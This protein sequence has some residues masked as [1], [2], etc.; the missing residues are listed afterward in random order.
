MDTQPGR[1][2]IRQAGSQPGSPSPFSSSPHLPISSSSLQALDGEA[3]GAEVVAQ[4]VED[5]AGAHRAAGL[6]VEEQEVLLDP[7]VQA[8]VGLGEQDEAG[9]TV[10]LKLVGLFSQEGGAGFFDGS[11]HDRPK[12]VDEAKHGGIGQPEVGQ[13]L[14]VGEPARVREW[15]FKAHG[16][17]LPNNGGS[18]LIAA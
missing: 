14:A 12:W 10:G 3:G 8:D 13:D 17:M 2:R 5:H 18:L 6:D 9:E 11:A 1:R 15:E 4:A 16:C 7:G